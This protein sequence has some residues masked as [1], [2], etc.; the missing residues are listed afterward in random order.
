M[1]LIKP[2]RDSSTEGEVLKLQLQLFQ[3][4]PQRKTGARAPI[5]SFG[6]HRHRWALGNAHLG[7]G[8]FPLDGALSLLSM[9]VYLV[10]ELHPVAEGP[11][12]LQQR[13]PKAQAHT[14]PE[15]STHPS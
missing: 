10:R 3:L 14:C 5:P 11:T 2:A 8:L 4:K 12:A 15:A 1:D 7:G 9:Q 6:V 13:S